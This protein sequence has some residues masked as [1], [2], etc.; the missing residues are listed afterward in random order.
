MP[1]TSPP[2]AADSEGSAYERLGETLDALAHATRR[3]IVL[4]LAIRG[5]MTAGAL[6]DRFRVA[7]PT[8]TR[9]LGVLQAAGVLR[10][11]IEGRQRI[12]SLDAS[13]LGEAGRWIRE[14]QQLD[15]R[16][17]RSAPWTSLPY[18]DMPGSGRGE[19]ALQAPGPKR[20]RRRRARP[21]A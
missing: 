8:V 14:V 4:T 2:P 19:A 10:V 5:P 17:G 15:A 1:R 21:Q 7:W 3:T 11:R 13:S 18:A 20:P 6:A 9:H 12:Y 16:P